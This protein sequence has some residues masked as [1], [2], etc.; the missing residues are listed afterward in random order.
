M[1]IIKLFSQ[2]AGS[3]V[4]SLSISIVKIEAA[5]LCEELVSYN[6]K[7]MVGFQMLVPTYQTTDVK[8]QMSTIR[9]TNL[10]PYHW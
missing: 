3:I 4:S 5:G 8:T 9:K 1:L 2:L 6:Y 10:Y 7:L